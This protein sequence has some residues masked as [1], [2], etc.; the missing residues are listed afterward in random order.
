M[1]LA[2]AL[3]AS[4]FAFVPPVYAYPNPVATTDAEYLA[5]GRVFSD[6]QGCLVTDTDG[7]GVNDVVP[8]GV[9]PWAKGNMCMAQFLSYEE[10]IEGT[11]YLAGRFP[12]FLQVIRLDQA[13]DNPNYHVRRASRARSSTDD[14][15]VKP[16][17]RDRRPL[18]MFKVTD[19]QSPIPEDM[20]LHF[21]YAGSIH[22]IERA[23]AEGVAAGHGR[24]R[25]LGREHAQDKKIVEAPTA[26]PVPTA[27]ETL[28][29]S[30]IYFM[31][32]N[33]DGWARGQV[34]PAELEDGSPEPAATR[35]A[36]STSATTATAWT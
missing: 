11:K 14:G 29:R 3:L 18:Y 7:D 34:A 19:S 30:V 10:A 17:D 28:A 13:Y 36:R 12:R 24:P 5:Y 27:G 32:P 25:H 1:P 4:V 20:R 16:I 15:T 8:P 22:G 26:K 9:S 33:P 6:P 2:G 23:G 35:P 31:L 21:V